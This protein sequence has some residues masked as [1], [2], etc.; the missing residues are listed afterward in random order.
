MFN[1]CMITGIYGGGALHGYGGD[2]F[3]DVDGRGGRGVRQRRQA[4]RGNMSQGVEREREVEDRG[5]EREGADNEGVLLSS[6]DLLEKS[7]VIHQQH[8]ERCYHIFYQLLAGGSQELLSEPST[9]TLPL[10][11]GLTLNNDI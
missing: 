10:P 1:V 9:I 11:E 7:R 5:R 3:K 6:T 2:R 8:G 4:S